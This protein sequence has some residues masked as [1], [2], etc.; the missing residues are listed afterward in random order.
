MTMKIHHHLIFVALC[1]ATSPMLTTQHLAQCRK[2]STQASK[3]IEAATLGNIDLVKKFIATGTDLD[4]QDS[5]GNTPLLASI[6]PIKSTN[7]ALLLIK[8]HADVTM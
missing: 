8:E 2:M 7:I 1:A 3:L 5:L 6:S 4:Q